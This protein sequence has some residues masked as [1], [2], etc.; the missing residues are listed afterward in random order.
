MEI[1]NETNEYYRGSLAPLDANMARLTTCSHHV[2]MHRS[3]AGTLG[4]LLDMQLLGFG[5]RRYIDAVV[6]VRRTDSW[7]R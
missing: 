1:K 4:L 3:A 6:F 7:L 2:V 5:V